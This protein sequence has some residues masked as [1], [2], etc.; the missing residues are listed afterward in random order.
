MSKLKDNS[1][2]ARL[3]RGIGL[4]SLLCCFFLGNSMILKADGLLFYGHT[5]PVGERTSY[6]VFEENDEPDMNGQLRLSFDIRINDFNT[7]GYIF[8]LRDLISGH[9]LSLTKR[10]FQ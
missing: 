6:R 3:G 7:F 9:E 2:F 1:F 4:L 8:H 5:Y 10:L